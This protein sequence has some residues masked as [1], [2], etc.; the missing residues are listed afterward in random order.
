MP[1]PNLLEEPLLPESRAYLDLVHTHSC[2]TTKSSEIFRS[3]GIT[4]Q[5]FHVLRVLDAA[6]PGGLPC[7]EV[8]RQLPTPAP[9]ITR[10]LERMRRAGLIQRQRLEADRRVILIDLREKGRSVLAA[11]L[12]RLAEFHRERLSHMSARELEQL[13]LLLRKARGEF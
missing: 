12:P 13:G 10:L 6:G 8:A 7:L 9:D 3:C 4:E 1:A 5:Q 11:V 2:I